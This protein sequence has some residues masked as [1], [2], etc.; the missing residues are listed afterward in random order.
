MKHLR[1]DKIFQVKMEPGKTYSVPLL[2]PK[3]IN[4]VRVKAGIL[5]FGWTDMNEEFI[6]S[7]NGAR[8]WK[9]PLGTKKFSFFPDLKRDAG[10]WHYG[11][12]ILL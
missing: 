2:N 8:F 10:G 11:D 9:I 1:F 3:V 4:C 6:H 7:R 5:S 12:I